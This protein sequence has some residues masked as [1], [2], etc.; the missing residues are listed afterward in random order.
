[1]KMLYFRY[2][3]P[4]MFQYPTHPSLKDERKCVM[5]ILVSRRGTLIVSFGRFLSQTGSSRNPAITVQEQ[6]AS[7]DSKYV[8]WQTTNGQTGPV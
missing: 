5:K 4:V 8:I 7:R 3:L 2:G 6:L 1:M